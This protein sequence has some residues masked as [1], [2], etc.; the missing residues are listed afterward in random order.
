MFTIFTCNIRSESFLG[1]CEL[2]YPALYSESH[3]LIVPRHVWYSS[4]QRSCFARLWYPHHRRLSWWTW[5][6]PILSRRNR[7][8]RNRR[9]PLRPPKLTILS[10]RNSQWYNRLGSDGRHWM[11]DQREAWTRKCEPSGQS[12]SCTQDKRRAGKSEKQVVVLYTLI[13]PVYSSS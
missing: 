3:S 1:T 4:K 2:K 12:N 9:R 11:V 13:I 6:M 10:R 8:R 7:K 5:R